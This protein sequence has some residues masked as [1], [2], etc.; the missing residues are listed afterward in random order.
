MPSGFHCR[1]AFADDTIRVHKC[2]GFEKFATDVALVATGFFTAAVGAFAFYKAVRQEALV[3]FAI[4]HLCVLGEY[5]AV[6]LYF[7]K[8]FLYEFFVNGAFG[9]CVIIEGCVP[10]AEEFCNAG[11]IAVCQSFRRDALFYGFYFDGCAMCV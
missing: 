8:G 7:E 1:L 2:G 5:V 10:F 4:K 9:A 11:V 6:L 3:V